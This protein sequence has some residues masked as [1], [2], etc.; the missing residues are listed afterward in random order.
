MDSEQ[1][2]AFWARFVASDAGAA[3]PDPMLYDTFSIG[4][5]TDSANAGATLILGGTKTATSS[6]PSE[7]GDH[8][9]PP[10][11]GALSIVLDGSKN[12][13][14]VV[15]T[16]EVEQ[17]QLGD[18]DDG[19]AWDYGE[20]DRSLPTLKA[21][22]RTYYAPDAGSLKGD[23]HGEIELLCERFRLVYREG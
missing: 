15:E 20:W 19:F 14:A 13:V 7:Y 3:Y 10:F 6:L 8:Q 18:L 17:K 5:D 16:T 22:L 11:A 9:P 4:S 2:Q 21:K 1:V 23:R 12:A